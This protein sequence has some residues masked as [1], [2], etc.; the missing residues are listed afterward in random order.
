MD[1]LIITTPDEL[2]QVIRNVIKSC[3]N[4]PIGKKTDDALPDI[5]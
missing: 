1:S 5:R 4:T 2:T 3:L